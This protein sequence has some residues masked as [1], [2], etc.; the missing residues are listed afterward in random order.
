MYLDDTLTNL[1]I[2]HAFRSN[3]YKLLSKETSGLPW[4]T[5]DNLILYQYNLPKEISILSVK[6]RRGLE[7]LSAKA[8]SISSIFL[9]KLF[10]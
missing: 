1:K 2:A 5:K 9:E 7:I 4:T 8:S 10:T 3:L 6:L